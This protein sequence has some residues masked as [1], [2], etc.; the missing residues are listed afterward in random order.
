MVTLVV[1]DTIQIA[2]EMTSSGQQ[3]F[4]VIGFRVDLISGLISPAGTLA[5]VKAA[6]E[7]TNGPLARHLN[8][9]TMVGYHY[10]DLRSSTGAT[11]FLG[12]SAVG[13]MSDFI[14]TMA[15]CAVVKLSANTRSRS[16]HGRLFHGP[17]G[18]SDINPDGRTISSTC[19]NGLT[20]AY[21]LL[22]SDMLTHGF[23]W[24]VISRKLATSKDIASIGVGSIIG[25]QRRR[26]R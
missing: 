7:Q 26:I 4:N 2:V 10:T 16:E 6:W 15:S 9:V 23:G 19:L 13:G 11:A 1:P 21:G 12:S 18:E 22:K 14:S 25:T 5:F 20:T 3:V 8:T 17:L 24:S